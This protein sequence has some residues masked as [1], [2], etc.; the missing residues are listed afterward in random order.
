MRRACVFLAA[1]FLFAVSNMYADTVEKFTTVG[2][3][4]CKDWI[5]LHD[6]ELGCK[7]MWR[8]CGEKAYHTDPCGWEPCSNTIIG[9]QPTG[10]ESYPYTTTPDHGIIYGVAPGLG[11]FFTPEGTPASC[12]GYGAWTFVA[13]G[14]NTVTMSPV[15]VQFPPGIH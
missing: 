7:T 3:D 8:N 15:M 14:S 13:D 1:C 9:G 4:G 2:I 5:I 12:G 11:G 6:D 10:W